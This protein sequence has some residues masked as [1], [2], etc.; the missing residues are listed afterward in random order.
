MK[1]LCKLC[2]NSDDLKHS[3]VLPRFLGKYLKNTSATGY[4]MAIDTEGRPSRGQD[5]Y[6]TKL[7]C[8][9]CEA[10]LN[11][12]EIFFAN[13]IFYPFQHRTLGTIPIDERLSRFAVSVSL[14]AL[15]IM[16][17]AQHPLVARWQKE[18]KEL[19]IEWRSYLLN[20]Q[21]FVKGHNSHHI[22]LCDENLLAVGVRNS[23]NLIYSVMRTSAY[24]LFEK[25]D[26]AYVFANLAGVQVISMI[27]PVELPVSRGTQVYP[28]QTFGVVTPPGIGW[29]G[30]YQNLL[31]LARELDAASSRLSEA[32][33]ERIDRAMN[34][35]RAAKSEDVRILKKQHQLRRNV[36]PEAK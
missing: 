23:P 29:G 8:S 32:Q 19:E 18:L 7:L 12:A 28:E 17:F 25:F 4:L 5:L 27:S 16:Q 35:E 13:T 24:Y 34:T 31:G 33:K 21:N 10:I 9:G 14:R 11:E 30:Y 20:S 26:K 3:H 22:L 1:P 15:W 6:K 36:P 2:L